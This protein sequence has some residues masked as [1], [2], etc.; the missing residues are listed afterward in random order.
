MTLDL[1]NGFLHARQKGLRRY[2]DSFLDKPRFGRSAPAADRTGLR[3][4]VVGILIPVGVLA[5]D[6]TLGMPTTPV[7]I[8]LGLLHMATCSTILETLTCAGPSMGTTLTFL[9][10]AV[11]PT[12]TDGV[13]IT[14]PLR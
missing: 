10:R 1:D 11:E 4:I 13:G 8:G 14:I 7:G 6:I 5:S 2:K 12:E 3:I 9:F